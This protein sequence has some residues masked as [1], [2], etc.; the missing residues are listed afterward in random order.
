MRITIKK[1]R[2]L[3]AGLACLLIAVL[4]GFLVY[5][6]YRIRHIGKDLPGK[7]GI[8]VQQTANG[9]VASWSDKG[10]TTFTI[11]ASKLVTFKNNGHAILHD[12]AITLYGPPG[13]NREDHVYGSDFDYDQK[14]GVASA[15]GEVQ[16]DLEAPQ[17]ANDQQQA[18]GEQAEKN[19]IHIK[20]SGLVFSQKTGIATTSQQV[21]FHLPKAAGQAVGAVFDSKQGTL[22]LE[23]QVEF[24][25]SENGEPAIVRAGH[26]Q[27]LRDT[28]QAFLLHAESEFRNERSSADEAILYF[29]K[30]G[31]VERIAAKGNVHTTLDSGAQTTS[32]TADISLD[33][34]SQPLQVLMGGG[35]NFLS[36]DAAQSMHGNA[37]EGTLT[38]GENAVLRHAQFRNAV[39]FVDQQLKLNNDPNGSSTRQVQAAKLDI[40]FALG[41]DKK[42]AAQKVLASGN[43][44]ATLRTISAKNPEQNTTIS[45]DQLLATLTE[46]R[47]IQRLDGTGHTKIIDLAHDGATNTS[48]GDT[49]HIT[50]SP[51][52]RTATNAKG[53]RALPAAQ[54]AQIETAVQDGNV[55]LTQ[56][57]ARDARTEN[58]TA[59]L[60][61]HAT[62]ARA[63]YHAVDQ[64]LHLTGNPRLNNGSIDLAAQLVDYHRDTG[65]ATAKGDVKATYLRGNHPPASGTGSIFGGQG[66]VHIVAQQA[67]LAHASGDSVFRGQARMWQGANAVAAPVIELSRT[68]Q[69]ILAHGQEKS[70]PQ[71]VDTT[72]ASAMGAKRQ[73][74]VIRIKSRTL[75]Y[76]DKERQGDF[77]GGVVAASPDGTIRS[78]KAQ[79]FLQPVPAAGAGRK[80][81]ES[82]A[83]QVEKII[84]SGD[85]VLTQP[86]RTGEGEKLVYTADDA[87]Y[88][89]TGTPAKPP[90]MYDAAHGTTTGEALIFNDRNDSV[91]ISGGQSAAVTKTRAPK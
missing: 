17:A 80:P 68:G 36:K 41:R 50:F 20:A 27:L 66:P 70:D 10:H 88:V 13:T 62:A 9:Y 43:A 81:Q 72:I 11:R 5:A 57:P 38:F 74:S 6:R 37:V 79:V 46:G 82:Q 18:S 90:Q 47:V 65:D 69:T 28:R 21:E 30:D 54:G 24:T 16:I 56:M 31:S 63:E 89:L 44:V 76:S 23:K 59:P 34:K 25:S 86:G 29:R 61:V 58:G 4:A 22:V 55:T 39:S 51:S 26:A 84:A 73:Q 33:E 3:I 64:V 49:L 60:P 78:E 67:D 42:I 83:S 53:Q 19:T 2:L 71:P 12:V 87:R 52:A 85:V 48:A 77:G 7:L 14:A 35:V 32:Q 8:N 1:L 91:E 45:G 75:T 15:Q 40:D